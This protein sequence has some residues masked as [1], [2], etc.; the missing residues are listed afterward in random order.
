V[1]LV[2]GVDMNQFG[3]LSKNVLDVYSAYKKILCAS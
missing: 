3:L 1:L 2:L